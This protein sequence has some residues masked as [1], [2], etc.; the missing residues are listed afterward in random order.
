MEKHPK[1][2]G[3]AVERNATIFL[4]E[5]KTLKRVINSASSW[6]PVF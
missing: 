1:T 6:A 5:T 3:L 4:T 2:N